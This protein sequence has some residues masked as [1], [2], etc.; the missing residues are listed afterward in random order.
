MLLP[1]AWHGDRSP[2][3]AV[4]NQREWSAR[5]RGFITIVPSWL[6]G[7][8]LIAMTAT[9]PHRSAALGDSA[10][11]GPGSQDISLHIPG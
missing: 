2:D 4:R 11:A 6:M 3:A 9:P 7:P 8:T 1:D 5:R 10:P